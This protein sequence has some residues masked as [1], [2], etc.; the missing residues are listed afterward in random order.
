[1]RHVYKVDSIKIF[2]VIQNLNTFFKTNLSVINT[3]KAIVR[4]ENQDHLI[5]GICGGGS[6][7]RAVAVRAD[8]MERQSSQGLNETRF[9]AGPQVRLAPVPAVYVLPQ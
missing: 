6:A 1:M 3:G 4:D 2:Y 7:L 9:T 8:T 5:H